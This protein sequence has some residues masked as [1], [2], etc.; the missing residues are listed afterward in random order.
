VEECPGD[1]RQIEAVLVGSARL[2]TSRYPFFR[3]LAR[4]LARRRARGPRSLCC[5]RLGTMREK[6]GGL[7]AATKVSEG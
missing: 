7:K 3:I 5:S 4:A 6:V 2:G 1:L